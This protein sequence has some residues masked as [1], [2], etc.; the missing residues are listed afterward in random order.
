L[1]EIT[2]DAAQS[3][4]HVYPLAF[5]VDYWNDLGWR[6]PFSSDLATGRQRAYAHLFGEHSVYT[7]Q[8]IVN[9]RDAFVGSD[10]ARALQSIE[11]ALAQPSV[12]SIVL[13]RATESD[14]IAVDYSVS[15]APPGTHL[16]AA[17]V[18]RQA[19]SKITSG[20][21]AGRT[22]HHANVVRALRTVSMDDGLNGHIAFPWHGP[23]PSRYAVVAYLQD[24][25]TLRITAGVRLDL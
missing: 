9:G 8:M 23:D 15:A 22:L 3:G 13:R 20:E 25:Q 11:S 19:V 18:E 5:H 24:P 16:R 6:D 7:P 2:M 10:R 17:L 4:R 21:N 14:G 1:R 12:A